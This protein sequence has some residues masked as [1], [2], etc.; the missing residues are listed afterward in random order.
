MQRNSRSELACPRCRQDNMLVI[1]LFGNFLC[2][3]HFVKNTLLYWSTMFSILFILLTDTL[4]LHSCSTIYEGVTDTE[5][6]LI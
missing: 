6:K 1:Y 3:E 5:E 2:I 4:L